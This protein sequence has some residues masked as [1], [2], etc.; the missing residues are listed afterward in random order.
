MRGYPWCRAGQF[1]VIPCPGEIGMDTGASAARQPQGKRLS[2]FST[3]GERARPPTMMNA[4]A[5]A[6]FMAAPAAS[7]VSAGVDGARLGLSY[8]KQGAVNMAGLHTHTEK[9][10]ASNS[11]PHRRAA[12]NNT[13]LPPRPRRPEGAQH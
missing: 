8:R 13:K 5:A 1:L 4:V 7:H 11:R 9:T 12:P 10:P 3:A 6:C 2:D